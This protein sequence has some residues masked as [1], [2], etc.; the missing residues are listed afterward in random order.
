MAGSLIGSLKTVTNRRTPVVPSTAERYY[1]V[2]VSHGWFIAVSARFRVKS[3][4][5]V[6]SLVDLMVFH[7]IIIFIVLRF[8]H[9]LPVAV[10]LVC[11]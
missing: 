4:P 7:I 9:T 8:I 2:T 10:S 1:R 6:N 11:Y 5:A 3:V